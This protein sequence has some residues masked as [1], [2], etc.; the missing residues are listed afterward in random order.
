MNSGTEF[1]VGDLVEVRSK[2]EILRTLDKNGRFEQ[3]PFMPQMFEYCGKRFRVSK[4]AHKFCDTAN[5]TGARQ[6]NNVVHLEDLRCSGRDYDGCQSA[7]LL[8]FKD[9]WLKPVQAAVA[10]EKPLPSSP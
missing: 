8:Y 4:R 9:V 7:C 5:S 1:R 6:I 2:D 10:T 3:V